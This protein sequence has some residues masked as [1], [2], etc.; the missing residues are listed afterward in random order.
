[1]YT[2]KNGETATRT[3]I[4]DTGWSRVEFNGKT[5][6]AVS[7]YLTTD[8]NYQPPNNNTE[9]TQP[10]ES[11][12]EEDTIQTQFEP[13]DDLVTAKDEVNLRTLPSITNE[14]SQVVVTLKHGETVKRTGVNLDL[15]WSRVEYNDQILYCVTSY[16]EIVEE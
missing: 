14:N 10:E 13:V 8:L 9:S 6:Y 4:S 16:L 12:T 7:S 5:Y 1:M 2:L 15:G 3:G 11:S